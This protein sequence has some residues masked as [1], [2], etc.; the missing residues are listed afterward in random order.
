MSTTTETL[1]TTAFTSKIPTDRSQ[2]EW[3]TVQL[4][5]SDSKHFTFVFI[6]DFNKVL[7]YW[8]TLAS[9]IVKG[10]RN[11]HDYTGGFDSYISQILREEKKR[12]KMITSFGN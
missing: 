8:L 10:T 3:L 1:Q 9:S 7:T 4:S 2:T 5:K 6:P 12:E 11:F